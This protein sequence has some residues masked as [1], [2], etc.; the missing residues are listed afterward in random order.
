MP[1]PRFDRPAVVHGALVLFAAAIV[2]KAA[3]VQLFQADRWRTSAARQQ[4]ADASLPAPR[5]AVTDANGRVLVESR[6][7]VQLRVA[8]REVRDRAGLRRALAAAG[9]AAPWVA[10]ASDSARA[11]VEIPGR[12]LPSDAAAA[13]AIRGVHAAPV[14]DRTSNAT[15]AVRRIV[16]RVDETGAPLDGV[17]LALDGV[18]RGERG[19]ALLVRDARGGRFESPSVR[20]VAARPG[21]TVVLTLNWT[22]QDICERALADA[23]ARMSATGGDI[24]V[25]EPKTGEVLALAGQRA[26]A[27]TTAATA[28]AE[29]FEPGSTAKPF[30]AAALLRLG[31]AH[32]DDVVNTEDGA[33][34]TNGRTI[35]DIHKAG[36]LS[37]RD[38]IR[39]SSNIGIVKFSSR[40][41][42]R[43]QYE[44]LRDVGFGTPTGVPYPA[45][46][47]GTLRAPG[48]W[49]KQS[50]ASLAMGYEVA[51]TPLQLAA[52]Y[53]AIANGGELLEPA[54]VREVRG[55]D[56]TVEF[57]HRPR[58]VRRV[59][60]AAVA[61]DVRA[62]LKSVV[63]SGTA[64]DADLKSF[65]FGG[66]SGT[67]RRIERGVGYA[68][69]HYNAVFAGIFPVESPQ[70]VIVVKLDNPEGVYFGGKT[71]APVTKVVLEAALAA[72]DAALDRAALAPDVLPRAREAYRPRPSAVPAR[73]LA[74][75]GGAARDSAAP[76]PASLVPAELRRDSVPAAEPGPVRV[77]LDL[78]VRVM[79]R[80]TGA[81]GSSLLPPRVVPPVQGLPVRDA[82]FALQR[83]GF[84]ARLAPGPAAVAAAR[85]LGRP[86][87]RTV[88][89][90][91][92]LAAAG[93]P[94]TLY[95]QP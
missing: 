73:S 41:T 74:E 35:H 59:M 28:I 63:D 5:G 29:P 16:G 51:A 19:T 67:V 45:E 4:V 13:A 39:F 12:Y 1:L 72:R 21:R 69:G 80:D 94:V 82:L 78:P 11:W 86:A 93:A 92:A 57:R 89:A 22:L 75:A 10:R 62:M 17:E 36:A 43:E 88:P 37:L 38:V 68:A 14:V 30:M 85:A 49:T 79:T 7:L 48:K 15:D 60:P 27:R 77:V 42:P 84:D 81:R 83:A 91:G 23:V 46:A 32:L 64:T 53:G 58:V 33:W 9:V 34:T 90:A 71:A 44:A 31:K 18:L 50:P 2:A 76:P 65:T 6:E 66:K 3:Q 54:L 26:D 87:F 61:A 40:L 70:F 47:S 56:G 25:L 24:V 95:R 52:A 8:P 20:S 55:A